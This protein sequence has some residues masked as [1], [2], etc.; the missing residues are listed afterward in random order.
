M[1][2]FQ[3]RDPTP[4]EALVLANDY[5]RAAAVFSRYLDEHDGDPDTLLWRE[6]PLDNLADAAV[7]PVREALGLAREGIV[8]CDADGRWVFATPLGDHTAADE[9]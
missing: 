3:F 4:I 1:L 6:L 2:V 9:G 5:D 8:T 7:G